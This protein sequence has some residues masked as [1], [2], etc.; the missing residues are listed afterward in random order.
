MPFNHET[1]QWEASPHCCQEQTDLPGVTVYFPCN[2]PA[3]RVVQHVSGE[4]PYRMCEPH[5]QHNIRNRRFNDLG[6]Y[7]RRIKNYAVS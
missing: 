5:A 7:D 1:E 6:V 4:G 2:Q 3:T